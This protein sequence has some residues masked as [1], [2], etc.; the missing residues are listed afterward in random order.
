MHLCRAN[1][2]FVLEFQGLKSYYQNWEA[3]RLKVTSRYVCNGFFEISCCN[4]DNFFRL[5]S[6]LCWSRVAYCR[7]PR[8]RRMLLL[9]TGGH[10]YRNVP[11]PKKFKPILAP[12][13]VPVVTPLPLFHITSSRFS[14]IWNIYAF[15]YSCQV[16][17]KCWLMVI[18]VLI[19]ADWCWLMMTDRAWCWLML[20]DS[21]R[22]WLVLID[23]DWGRLMLNEAHWCWLILIETD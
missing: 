8:W 5:S 22:S 16:N 13:G 10:Y 11:L 20:I 18:G 4:G 2:I 17:Y 23:A 12:T 14:K 7:S 1:Y 21:D 19:D 9:S 3:Q 15:I 6:G